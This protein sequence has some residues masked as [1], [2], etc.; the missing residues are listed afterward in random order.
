M[1]KVVA[2]LSGG[3]AASWILTNRSTRMIE[4]DYPLG[5]KLAL[6]RKDLGIALALARDTGAQLPVA[7]MAAQFEDELIAEGHGDEDNSALARS[8]RRL[9]G[10]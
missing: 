7:T 10:F 8:V 4:D 2:A 3:A 6:H 5:F 1:D 9:S